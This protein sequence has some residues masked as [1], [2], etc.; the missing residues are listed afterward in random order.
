MQFILI[1]WLSCR[2]DSIS[3]PRLWIDA[4][5]Q[6]AF[7]TGAGLGHYAVYSGFFKR[8]DKSVIYSITLPIINNMVR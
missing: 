8:T 3:N 6:N 4:F 7:D 1:K 2:L 5:I